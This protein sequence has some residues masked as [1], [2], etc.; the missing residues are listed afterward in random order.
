MA[1]LV[2][3][4]LPSKGQERSLVLPYPSDLYNS[5]GY[6]GYRYML[7][8]RMTYGPNEG[9]D[10]GGELGAVVGNG[11][12]YGIVRTRVDLF[13]QVTFAWRRFGAGPKPMASDLF[14]DATLAPLDNPSPMLEW[15]ELDAATAGSSFHVRDGGKVRRLPPKWCSI[16]LGSQRYPDDPATAWDAEPIGLICLAPNRPANE[17]EVFLWDEVIHY[18]P[19]RDPEAR[20]R[21]MSYL[22]PVMEDVASDNGA[23]RYLTRFFEN[24]ATPN[25]A[26]VFP[27][28][29]GKEIVEAYRD[30]F[31]EK[32]QGVDRA[33]RTAFL[34]AGADLKVV[35]TNLKDLDT[36]AVRNQIHIDIANAAG[37]D[38]MAVGLLQVNYA[39]RK[40]SNRALADRKL[41]YLWMK[42]VEALRPAIGPP[43]AGA[44]LWYDASAVSALQADQL[45]DAQV[46]AQQAQTMRT[47]ID[48]GFDPP[49]VTK[50]VTTGD[51]TK[52]VHSGN[53]SV[54]LIPAGQVPAPEP[55]ALPAG[56]PT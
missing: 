1:R 38:P 29:I 52:L 46:Q 12:V 23:R 49:S 45:D 42:A 32:H 43:P 13:S 53:L 9:P 11:T 31:L 30:F 37:V 50:A 54:Q 14:T 7:D 33:F 27:P 15:F 34:G 55:K 8:G 19:E 36:E 21:G 2:D 40:E 17:A 39:N 44:S 51:M 22:R 41:R 24:S 4:L 28:E 20:Y 35:G 3:R 48:G 18:C 10:Y 5:I 6:A 16:V 56:E 26:V 47:L 25:M